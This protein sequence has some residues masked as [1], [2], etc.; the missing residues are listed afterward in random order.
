MYRYRLVLKSKL[1][2]IISILVLQ[3]FAMYIYI[4]L[5]IISVRFLKYLKISGYWGSCLPN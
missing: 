5:Y 3:I 4:K 1:L 2:V